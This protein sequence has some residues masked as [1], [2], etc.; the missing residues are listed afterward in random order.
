MSPIPSDL[1]ELRRRIDEIDDRLQE[2]LIERFET[3]LRVAAQKR[4]GSVSPYQPAREAQIIRRLIARNRPPY[5]PATL[6]RMWRELLAGT[7][8]LQGPFRVAVYAPGDAPRVW[9]LARDHYGSHTTMQPHP[10][11]GAV[12][13]AVTEG[14]AEIGVLPMP[15]E[16]EP[17]PWWRLLV[18]ADGNTP[19]VVA[20]LPFGASGNARAG[21]ADA[22]VIGGGAAQPSGEDRTLFAAEIAP[23]IS[24]G[25]VFALL[26][27]MGL[28][29]T[30]LAITN[31]AE[32]ANALIELRGFVALADPRLQ[33]LRAQLGADLYRLTEFG[34]YAEP[35]GLDS[36]AARV[37][38][39]RVAR[40]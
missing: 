34:A 25:R 18:S 6:V 38:D 8:R 21:R 12:I 1:G 17:D 30:F 39:P 10:S 26:S 33:R 7:T 19:R 22:L 13:R 36:T 32:G 4:D 14:Q 35:L 37:A 3:V 5:Q 28:D 9:D 20:R 16:E 40:G 31:G 23:N 24:R 29:C 15:E 11:A 27:A 2:L